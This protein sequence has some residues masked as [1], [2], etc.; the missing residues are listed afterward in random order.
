MD[1]PEC[2]E[3]PP[4][5]PPIADP[6]MFRPHLKLKLHPIHV[7][8]PHVT[9]SVIDA[10]NLKIL[11]H[12]CDVLLCIVSCFQGEFHYRSKLESAFE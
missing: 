8:S 9:C 12:H 10:G 1:C 4:E 6:R 5:P 2:P 7:T 3:C 11:H